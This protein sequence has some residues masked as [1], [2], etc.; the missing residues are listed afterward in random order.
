MMPHEEDSKTSEHASDQDSRRRMG[1]LWISLAI[2]RIRFSAYL[3]LATENWEQGKA[4]DG[5][6]HECEDG[7][8]AIQARGQNDTGRYRCVH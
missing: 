2:H 7:K 4:L 6:Q 8:V 1:Q 5:K 3:K